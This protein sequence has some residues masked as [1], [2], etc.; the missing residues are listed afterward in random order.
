M[1]TDR[2]LNNI[3]HFLSPLHH[4]P[5][6]MNMRDDYIIE[7]PVGCFRIAYSPKT[8]S[9]ALFYARH[10]DDLASASDHTGEY[11]IAHKERIYLIAMYKVHHDEDAKWG[12]GDSRQQFDITWVRREITRV[13][14]NLPRIQMRE[15]NLQRVAENIYSS[16]F[17]AYHDIRSSIAGEISSRIVTKTDANFRL[18]LKTASDPADEV[19]K[20]HRLSVFRG[21]ARRMFRRTSTGFFMLRDNEKT[22]SFKPEAMRDAREADFSIR[23]EQIW[24]GL[25][26]VR[27]KEST[28]L[29]VRR[30]RSVVGKQFNEFMEAKEGGIEG[31]L[32]YVGPLLA[33]VLIDG[34]IAVVSSIAI[35]KLGLFGAREKFMG[36]PKQWHHIVD[37]SA[38]RLLTI[39]SALHKLLIKPDAKEFGD[40]RWLNPVEHALNFTASVP[41]NAKRTFQLWLTSLFIAPYASSFEYRGDGYALLAVGK[42]DEIGKTKIVNMQ[43]SNGVMMYYVPQTGKIYGYYNQPDYTVRNRKLPADAANYFQAG[44]VIEIDGLNPDTPMKILPYGEFTGIIETIVGRDVL[45][46]PTAD[47][48]PDSEINHDMPLRSS[49]RVGEAPTPTAQFK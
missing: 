47:N 12:S 11:G 15:A 35:D 23:L 41:Q 27:W 6:N 8:H 24:A 20:S 2:T 48:L 9:T 29:P 38:R 10:P 25:D 43:T 37:K 21:A 40:M 19:A 39:D 26:P 18:A 44:K 16:A 30:A 36:L 5:M 46:L 7:T 31:I 14:H 22:T 32:R 28:L 1:A 49:P 4:M 13:I 45:E 3:L 33:H 42:S 17:V 34:P